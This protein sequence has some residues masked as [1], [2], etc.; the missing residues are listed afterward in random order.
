MKP[1]SLAASAAACAG[2]H[3][4]PG[5]GLGLLEAWPSPRRCACTS[6]SSPRTCVAE[7]LA[8]AGLVT[9]Q[10]VVA[11]LDHGL[12]VEGHVSQQ[13]LAAGRVGGGLEGRHRL[14]RRLEGAAGVGQGDRQAGHERCPH[15]PGPFLVREVALRRH[16][17]MV[18]SRGRDRAQ[19]PDTV[20]VVSRP[21]RVTHTPQRAMPPSFLPDS[22]E[23]AARC[24]PT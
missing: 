15:D 7:G 10:R 23:P 13:L 22:I 8:V 11:L 3:Q 21:P 19:G 16:C 17:T 1:P 20:S 2:G 12:D 6:R 18:S 9:L 14:L 24:M 4:P 5:E